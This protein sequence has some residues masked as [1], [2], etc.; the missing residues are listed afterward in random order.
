MAK[1]GWVVSGCPESGLFRLTQERQKKQFQEKIYQGERKHWGTHQTQSDVYPRTTPGWCFFPNSKEQP[2]TFLPYCPRGW[3]RGM[4]KRD[5]KI[6]DFY[7]MG[8]PVFLIHRTGLYF[9]QRTKGR[10]N[11]TFSLENKSSHLLFLIFN[12]LGLNVKLY[13]IRSTSLSV[14]EGAHLSRLSEGSYPKLPE[15]FF[16]CSHWPK[17]HPHP[18]Q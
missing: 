12:P 16:L 11:L 3:F 15:L 14:K 2:G 6:T 13:S 5:G 1:I 7:R 8:G 17:T 10:R 9:Q 4:T 18:E